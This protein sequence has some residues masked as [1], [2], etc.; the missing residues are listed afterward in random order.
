MTESRV[1]ENGNKGKIIIYLRYVSY[2]ALLPVAELIW[3]NDNM[4]LFTLL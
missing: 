4:Q 1:V 3:R 2:G